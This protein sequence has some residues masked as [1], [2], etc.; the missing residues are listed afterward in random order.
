ML[1]VS[2][3]PTIPR[4]AIYDELCLSANIAAKVLVIKVVIIGNAGVYQYTQE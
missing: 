1:G 2:T 4:I 3:A